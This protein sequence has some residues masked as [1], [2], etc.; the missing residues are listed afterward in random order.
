MDNYGASIAH[1]QNTGQPGGQFIC[2]KK[3]I[4]LANQA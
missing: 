4:I 3:N 1:I 2:C